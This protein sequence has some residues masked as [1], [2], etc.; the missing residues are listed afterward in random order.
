MSMPII[1]ILKDIKC[2][3]ILHP[4][5]TTK[6]PSKPTHSSFVNLSSNFDQI[7]IQSMVGWNGI[8]WREPFRMKNDTEVFLSIPVS[9]F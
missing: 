8:Y 3:K 9:A 2:A 6:Y 7:S 4:I 1:K 5:H